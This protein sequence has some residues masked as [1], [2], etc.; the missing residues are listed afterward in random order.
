MT[1]DE[2]IESNTKELA[3][4]R[5]IGMVRRIDAIRLSIEALNRE[6]FNRE[7]PD[8]VIVGKLPGETDA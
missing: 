3:Y 2:A 7:N 8:F 5:G 4:V 6:K 1:I